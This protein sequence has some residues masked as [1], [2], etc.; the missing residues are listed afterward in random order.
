VRILPKEFHMRKVLFVIPSLSVG[1]TISSLSGIYEKL[2][3]EYFI[4]VYAIVHSKNVDVP[5]RERLL[6]RNVVIHFCN[7]NL[8]GVSG[9]EK[10]FTVVFKVVKKICLKFH[11]DLCDFFYRKVSKQISN[12]YDVIVGFEEGS[13]TKLVSMCACENKIAWVHC[14]YSRYKFCGEEYQYYSKFNRIICV[15]KYT[16]KIFVNVYPALKS[17]V[18]YIHNILDYKRI[19]EKSKDVID[20]NRFS[21]KDFTILS[22]GRL[23]SVKR[24]DEIP[25]IANQIRQKGLKFKWFIIG[26]ITTDDSNERIAD[27]INKYGVHDAVFYLGNKKNPY[28]Y[29]RACNLL[30]SLSSSEACPMIFNEAKVLGVPIVTTNFPSSYEFVVDEVEGKIVPLEKIHDVLIRMISDNV[31]YSEFVKRISQNKYSNKEI[32]NRLSNIFSV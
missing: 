20:D 9:W 14:D 29:F 21:T 5:F 23:S 18:T 28:P 24:F 16:S 26:P 8:N 32:V 2:K 27:N 10:V 25:R 11:F 3:D 13:A 19:I 6:K 31:Y 4:A 17:K 1:G 7:A 12:N 22:V 30:V 15:S